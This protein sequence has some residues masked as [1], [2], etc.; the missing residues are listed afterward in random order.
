MPSL[1]RSPNLPTA[2]LSMRGARLS[3][4]FARSALSLSVPATIW[5][6]SS[7][8]GHLDGASASASEPDLMWMGALGGELFG[9]PIAVTVSV[10][11]G[12]IA[13]TPPKPCREAGRRRSDPGMGVVSLSSL[14][15]SPLA[16]KI[17]RRKR[18]CSRRTGCYQRLLQAMRSG[19]R[20]A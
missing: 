16:V 17:C 10:S 3:A 8:T 18:R 4:V 2:A 12:T 14:G 20:R 13:R 1:K 19:C 9:L 11:R 5:F 7:E 15:A 6:W